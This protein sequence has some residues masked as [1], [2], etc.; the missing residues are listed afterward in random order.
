M[1]RAFNI[2]YS[3]WFLGSGGRTSTAYTEARPGQ[4]LKVGI[5]SSLMKG[6]GLY[7]IS[8][9]FIHWASGSSI[10]MDYI[11]LCMSS[12]YHLQRVLSHTPIRHYQKEC[13]SLL[14]FSAIVV[15]RSRSQ[16]RNAEIPG[17]R[18]TPDSRVIYT[19]RMIYSPN[20]SGSLSSSSSTTTV[21]RDLVPL[22]VEPLR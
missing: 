9:K 20:Q 5:R 7:H 6:N 18:G 13:Q 15:S 19:E 11:G 1:W 12:S 8:Q 22:Y 17:A 2:L 14:C 21:R 3:W 10:E 4:Y 16:S